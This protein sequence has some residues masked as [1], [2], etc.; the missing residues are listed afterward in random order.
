MDSSV[1][2][3][4]VL[5]MPDGEISASASDDPLIVE[6]EL[7]HVG[8]FAKYDEKTGKVVAKYNITEDYLNHW[9]KTFAQ[10]AKESVDV[11]MPLMHTKNPEARR[12]TLV[13][14]DRRKNSKGVESLFGK[15][16]FKDAKSKE[17]LSA[18]QVSI[19]VPKKSGKYDM[20]IEHVAFTDYPVISTLEP[21]NI[22]ASYLGEYEDAILLQNEDDDMT[23]KDLAIQA[24]LDPALTDEQQILMALSQKLAAAN[25]AK[26]P[27]PPAA[28]PGPPRPPM[29]PGRFSRDNNGEQKLSGALLSTVREL[30]QM[31]LSRLSTGEDAR[32]TPAQA[33]L[34]ADKYCTDDALAF[35][36]LDG[37]SDDFDTTIEVLQA[38]SPIRGAQKTGPQA[39]ALSKDETQTKNR[40]V[41]NAEAR[42]AAAKEQAA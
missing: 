39:M 28:P 1:W 33:K 32:I 6:K 3:D 19:Y 14:V 17:N 30:R 7:V 24:G 10:M 35:S 20:P 31:K 16:K 27:V 12:A 26:P 36:H 23:L 41:A 29:P 15:V 13:G 38:G 22:V 40:L 11:P 25:A 8:E 34:L 5:A 37:A 18:S 4:L 21:F 9:Q 42:A 2:L